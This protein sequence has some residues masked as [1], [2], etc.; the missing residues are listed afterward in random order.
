M[1]DELEQD[2][3]SGRAFGPDADRAS[4]D[5]A[6]NARRNKPR[7]PS[8]PSAEPVTDPGAVPQLQPW[9]VRARTPLTAKRIITA[10]KAKAGSEQAHQVL[11]IHASMRERTVL[12]AHQQELLLSFL[13]RDP[14]TDGLIDAADISAMKIATGLRVTTRQAEYLI[15]DAHRSVELMPETFAILTTGDLPEGFHQYLLRQVRSLTDEQTRTVD[16]HVATWELASISRHMFE[17][18]MKT[19]I[20][21]VTAG[22]IPTLPETQRRVD[23][24]IADHAR[25]TASLTITGPT[26]EIK[27]LA[28]RLD[29]CAHT[30]Q[31]AQR[32]A[33]AEG[34]EGP[35]PFDLDETLH[36]RGRPLSLAALRYGILTHSILDIDPVPEPANPYRMLV[37]VPAMTLLG[38]DNAPGMIDGLIP[39]PAEQAR[40]LAAGQAT[41]QRILTDPTTGAY[42]P[43]TAETYT[44]T[45]Q[46]RLQLRLRHPVCAAPGCTRPTVLASED[47]H[48]EE[49]HHEHPELG[50]PTSL[51]NLH[52]L[53][54]LHHK[55]KTEGLIDPERDEPGSTAPDTATDTLAIGLSPPQPPPQRSQAVESTVTRWTLDGELRT[56]TRDNVDLLTP[57]LARALDNAWQ[58]HLRA[59]DDA[60]RL[61]DDEAQRP[62]RDRVIEQRRHEQQRFV[63]QRE[64]RRGG[65]GTDHPGGSTPPPIRFDDPPPF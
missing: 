63:R 46:M 41:W 15:R 42:L 19:L 32:R 9:A 30:V 54:W 28:H 55:I 56:T 50:G 24:E 37:T 11:A 64:R 12:Y 5:R 23:L 16:H 17:T 53:C 43:V 27:A 26:L 57:I 8:S 1:G 58:T 47:D 35:I 21:R 31:K 39:V 36:D 33:L 62:K 10:A 52:R 48:I 61:R 40:A 2:G 13:T 38:I 34:E 20:T 22:T 18:H 44:P 29:V 45:A 59:H 14:E 7:D 49:F 65:R 4:A 60:V 25:G 6:R 51:A 3:A